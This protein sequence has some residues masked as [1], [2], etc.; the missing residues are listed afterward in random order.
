MNSDLMVC[1]NS[2]YDDIVSKKTSFF[3][4]FYN[5]FKS[6]F[7]NTIL[8]LCTFKTPTQWAYLSV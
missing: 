6:M 3:S 8:H 4:N 5:N 2:K 1:R 7:D